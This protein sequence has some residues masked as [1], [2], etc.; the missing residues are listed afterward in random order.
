M[1]LADE[2]S[3]RRMCPVTIFLSLA[4]ADRVVEGVEKGYQ[5]KSLNISH[6]PE[7]KVLKYK[8][9]SLNLPIMRRAIQYSIS[10]SRAVPP[11][12]LHKMIHAQFQRAGHAQTLTTIREDNK[13][14]ADRERKR[15]IKVRSNEFAR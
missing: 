15:R 6:F 14:A 12:R 5:I 10:P 4:L 8:P 3:K 11:D 7:W 2:P 1:I 13:K 9:E